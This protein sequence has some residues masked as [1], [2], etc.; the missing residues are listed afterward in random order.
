LTYLQQELERRVRQLDTSD[1][2]AFQ[3][4]IEAE[5]FEKWIE[6][7]SPV[8]CL[9]ATERERGERWHVVEKM[10]ECRPNDFFVPLVRSKDRTL[11]IAVEDE[12][13]QALELGQRTTEANDA[14]LAETTVAYAQVLDSVVRRSHD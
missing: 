11:L 14:V 10:A 13:V 4:P 6:A 5:V 12:R 7:S 3:C 2:E 9:I 8:V 1:V